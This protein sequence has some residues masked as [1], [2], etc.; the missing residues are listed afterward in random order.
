MAARLAQLALGVGV[1][2]LC[3]EEPSEQTGQY[4]H[5]Q[6]EAGFAAHPVHA[7]ERYPAGGTIISI[8]G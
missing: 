5:R 1:G 6:Q 2:E 8:C 4:G 3:Q 7:F